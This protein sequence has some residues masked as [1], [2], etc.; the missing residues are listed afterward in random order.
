LAIGLDGRWSPGRGV[1]AHCDEQRWRGLGNI[2]G[3]ERYEH[4]GRAVHLEGGRMVMLRRCRL[5]IVSVLIGILLTPALTPGSV[6]AESGSEFA[7]IDRYV[8]SQMDDSRIPGVAIA[9]VQGNEIV[10]AR[11]FGDGIS[12]QTPFAIGSLTKSFTALAVMQLMEAGQIE[13]DAPVQRY[14]PWF[15][16]AD[17]I[18]SS[19]ITVRHLLNQTSG[20]SRMTGIT[21]L[22]EERKDSTEQ[23]VRNLR[24]A[25]LNRPVG[26]SYE[27]SNANFVTLGLLIETVSGKTYGDYVQTHI[28]EPLGMQDS[29]T[30]H[31]EGRQHGM[32]AVHRF[33][34]G[35]PVET[36]APQLPAQIPTGF[37]V[38]S[39]ED[40]A[41]YLTMYLN[42][43]EYGGER[44]LSPEGIAMM[45]TPATNEFTRTLLSTDFTA[46]YGMG[47]FVGPFGDAQDA[48]WHL[49]ELPSFNAWMVVMPERDQAV[50]VLINAGS[51]MQIAGV[52]E[53]FSRIPIGVTN[54]LGGTEP[55]TGMSLTTFYLFFN[56]AVVLIVLGQLVALARL[57]R[58]DAPKLV[59][60]REAR[61][62]FARL[63][64][65]LPLAW[66][67]GLGALI[68]VGLPAMTG[69]SWKAGFT[70]TPDL[71]ISLA[72]IASIWLATGILRVLKP[73][74]A[75]FRIRP[76][77]QRTELQHAPSA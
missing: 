57:T 70:S 72:T 60:P 21:P 74:V 61:E 1:A 63:S 2:R 20:L 49:G 5:A 29:Y 39:A 16:V 30:S 35:V 32:A 62:V 56:I 26:A 65:I 59:R 8:E 66:E 11:G 73:F 17:P 33:W 12:A 77:R 10:H 42:G 68:L 48:R 40:M 18:A 69:L 46:R 55:P 41:R 28:F 36:E 13:L 45:H 75:H 14:I 51:Q 67:L 23:Y 44:L 9:I 52:T 24:T 76:T 47:W 3:D 19:Q 64:Y 7:D 6:G 71:I 27:Y 54:M 53:V 22:L 38:A 50:V 25:K 58:R 34:F 15:Q 37:L 4:S 31:A 43:G